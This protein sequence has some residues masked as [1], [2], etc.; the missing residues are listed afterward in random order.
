[1]NDD[2]ID[3]RNETLA[4]HVDRFL[5]SSERARFS[6]GYLFLPGL[7][8]IVDSVRD[9][10]EL[11]LLI[12]SPGS[13]ETVEQL[14]EGYQS[15]DLVVRA[16]DS[17]AYP[18][19]AHAKRVLEETAEG[20]RQT[21]A[22]MEQTDE[23]ERLIRTLLKMLHERRLKVRIY[24]KGRLD[25]KHYVFDFVKAVTDT[26]T[27]DRQG[28]AGIA[29]VGATNLTL[30]HVPS[31]TE[32]N[33]IIRGNENHAGLTQAFERLWEDSQEFD[34]TLA[35][36]LAN[37]W[38]GRQAS[39]Y[40]I[41][42]KTLYALVRDRLEGTDEA[43]VLW[44]DEITESLADFQ[45]VA[46]RQGIQIIRDCGGVFVS[47][48][49]GL[50]KSYVGAAIV[51]HFERIEHVRPLVICPA[52][53]V[54]MWER[55]NEVY[56]LNARVLSMGYLQL[57][58]DD[59]SINV[60][61]SDVR[62]R[63]RDF[64]LVD[65]SHNFRHSNTQRYRLLQDFLKTGIRCCFLTATPRNRSAWDIYNQLKL[66]HQDDKTDLPISPP[67]LKEYFRQVEN[68]AKNLQGLLRHIL[69]RRLRKHILRF[70]GYDAMTNRPVDPA[71]FHEYADG[72]RKAYVVI[73]G[74]HQFFPER[75]LETVDYSIEDT[76]QGLY[77]QLRGYL[78]RAGVRS[79]RDA[80][81]EELTY[82]RYGLWHYVLPGKQHEEPYNSLEHAGIHLRGLIRVLLFKRFES[83]VHAFRETVRR[84][85]NMHRRFLQALSEG[86]VPAG[87]DAQAILYEPNDA[88]EQDIIEALREAS[89][90][91]DAAHFDV[92]LLS[93]H[94]Q[95]DIELLQRMLGLVEPIT[96][97]K[98]AKLQRLKKLLAS[99][100]LDK[101][102]LLIFTQYTETARYLF[103]NL[104][105]GDHKR[106]SD[107]VCSGER[108]RGEVVGRFA[109]K[110]NPEHARR[111]RDEIDLLIATDVFAEGLNLQD[112]DRIINYDLHW[113]PVRLIQRFGRIDRI[114]TEHEII[115]AYNFLPETEL[116]RNIGL[117]QTLRNRIQEIHDT[118]GE[119]SAILDQTERLNAE[120]MYAI[121][122]T[123]GEQLSLFE[124][125]QEEEVMD[126]S[127]GEEILRQMRS[128]NP[129]EYKR[130]GE[131]R[132]GIRA[133]RPATSQGLY[134]FCQAGRFQKLLLLDGDGK[135][136][137]QEIPSVLGAIRADP[138][139][140]GTVLP[141]AH[142]DS[143]TRVMRAFAREAEE[144]QSDR[145][146]NISVTRGQRYALRELGAL[147]AQTADQDVKDRI[148][149]LDKAFREPITKALNGDLNRIR[150]NGMTGR[151]LLD[152]LSKLYTQHDLRE[153]I[154][155]RKFK[156]DERP[157]PSII[158]SEAFV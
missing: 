98:D 38:A 134:V 100:A 67:D 66:F 144:R 152:A 84:L 51:K 69:I 27:P 22:L 36:E 155:R 78:G 89:G 18:K 12:S 13:R 46:V 97:D 54:D 146:H 77:Q 156:R 135:A 52:S 131:L 56:H 92:D 122:E 8:C 158:C 111:A 58:P 43:D 42:M 90:R 68:G 112:C 30:S 104:S 23:G 102:K 76:Y 60:L 150:A 157:I 79:R 95:K 81:A 88:E 37:G 147:F 151:H 83:S 154:E 3:N 82:A 105:P 141:P 87:E 14:V 138:D 96:P 103:D 34:R 126:L 153:R 127:E 108:N 26:S 49:V 130:I 41:Y 137:S 109:P 24:N 9:V 61:R 16:I 40:D 10:K 4:D 33:V 91:Y 114:G 145:Q 2:I 125:D 117:R 48:V 65:E 121:Y 128:D 124:E 143:V 140:Q 70:Y 136:V 133:A 31:A 106:R 35:Y 39:P 20:V 149:V 5:R 47:D 119:D 99:D 113:N 129:D 142:N 29:I 148:V 50:G 85:L 6:L 123:N 19:R 86:I 45:K 25:S 21:M 28:N 73:G 55:Y 63:D 11:S 116:D 72:R 64:V 132:D 7:Q 15:L 75:K 94:L 80:S 44:D 59:D 101:S 32:V 107:V 110:A 57:D 74:R 120:A 62:Y 17:D 1:M 118:I 71:R 139:L 93:K 115:Y 53:L